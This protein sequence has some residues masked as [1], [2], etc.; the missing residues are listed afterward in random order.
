MQMVCIVPGP[1]LPELNKNI[2]LVFN[3]NLCYPHFM[4]SGKTAFLC[5]REA[6]SQKQEMLQH[7]HWSSCH[8]ASK[9]HQPLMVQ[10][11]V[12]SNLK[13]LYCKTKGM[14]CARS[15]YTIFHILAFYS[16]YLLSWFHDIW[17]NCPP[18]AERLPLL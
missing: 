12:R 15:S 1:P 18:L 6:G 11:I 9:S 16:K 8:I 3:L 17:T 2:F 5:Q 14:Y 10:C 13:K 7:I 4:T